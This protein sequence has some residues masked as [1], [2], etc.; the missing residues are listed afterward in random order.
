[1]TK[2]L[3]ISG[4]F[5]GILL[6]WLL[7]LV[8]VFSFAIRTSP[9]QTYLAK[10][11][12]K[13]LSKELHATL[14]IDNV[15]IIFIDKVEL[16]G[17]LLEDQ[18]GDTILY[19][20]SL[21]ASIDHFHLPGNIFAL[22]EVEID[23]G[24]IAIE[25]DKDGRFSYAFLIDY[26][27]RDKKKEKVPFK[28][29]V[30]E[31]NVTNTQ[32]TYDDH[33]KSPSEYGIDYFHLLAKEIDTKVEDFTIENGVYTGRIASLECQ[34]K[35]GFK[36]D[37]LS[38]DVRVD[39]SGV[40]LADVKI[41]SPGS[42]V[43]SKKFNMRSTGLADFKTFV[44]SVKFDG[45]LQDS[46]V[47]LK[48]IAYFAPVLE[49][50]IDTLTVRG[51]IG[52]KTTNLKLSDIH[53]QYGK[54]TSLHGTFVI[55]DY[56]KFEKGF[57]HEQIHYASINLRE[58]EQIR[59]PTKAG[60]THIVLDKR[61]KRLEHIQA[62]DIKMTGFLTQ[63]VIAAD[64]ITT[65]LGQV[66]ADNGI[67][68]TQYA[69]SNGYFFE[70]SITNEYDVKIE[71]F[72]L[73][74]MLAN[75]TLGIV[76]G[77]FLLSGEANS[78]SDVQFSSIRGK[79]D[80]FDYL[81]YPYTDI[82]ILEGSL[83]DERFEGTIEVQ[84][85]NLDM[86]YSGMV[87]FKT[88]LHLLFTI[89][90][91]NALLEKLNITEDDAQVSSIFTVDLKGKNPDN[92]R[93]SVRMNSFEMTRNQ[94]Y[95]QVPNAELKIV[96]GPTEDQFTIQS[97]ILQL[98]VRGKLYLRHI[99]S[100]FSNN[101]AGVF[102]ALIH[103]DSLIVDPK[104]IDHFTFKAEFFDTK[105][106]LAIFYPELNIASHTQINGH[107][108][109]AQQELKMDITSDRLR[110]EQMEFTNLT[111]H[112]QMSS[113]RLILNFHTEHYQLNDSINFSNVFFNTNGGN[114]LLESE[115][116]WGHPSQ[117]PSNISWRT[118]VQSAEKFQ[119]TLNPSYFHL[120]EKKWE[121]AHSSEITVDSDTL[122]I[123]DFELTRKNQFIKLNGDISSNDDH[124][125]HFSLKD[126]LIQEFS[127]L[128]STVPLEGTVNA[129]GF[130]SN[131]F[132]NFQFQGDA[133]IQQLIAKNNLV[134][135]VQLHSNW[136][137]ST[138]SMA[139]DGN[140][141]Y[142]GNQTFDFKG[143]YFPYQKKDNLDFNLVFDYMDIQFVN[144][145]MN[146]EVLADI[147]G[148]LNGT[149][150]V[151][152][153]IDRPILNGAVNLYAGSALVDIVGAHFGVEG[154]IKADQYGFYIDGIPVYDEDGNAGLMIGSIYHDNFNNF[155]FDLV[156]DLEIDA[157]NK[158][159]LRPW[160]PIPLKRFLLLNS[161]YEQGAIYHG[162]GYGTGMI[163]LFGYTDNLEVTVDIVTQKGTKIDIPMYGMG[164]I[165]EEN[166]IVF[167]D[168]DTTAEYIEPKIDFTGVD[169][170]LNFKITP[171][172]EVKIIF[173]KEL[174]DE[175]VARGNGDLSIGLNNIGDVRMNGV[176][177]VDEGVYNFAMG[178][179]KEKFYLDKG[180]SISW[181][182]DPYD[183]ILNLRAYYKV[184]ANIAAATNDQ[185]GSGSG[186]HQE[187]LC[188]LDLT[189]SLI[190]PTIDFD[191]EAPNANEVA[192]SVITR[193][194]SDEDELNRQFF[195]LL[196]WKRFQPL[197]GNLS[198]DGSAAID[199]ITNQI[200]AIL[201]KVSD[202]YK[203]NVNMD[204]DELTGDNTYEFGVSKGFLND[205]LILSGS[206]GV[207]NR[208]KTEEL[209][210][211]NAI[212][213]DIN[214][215]YLLNESGTFRVNIFNESND[216]TII[217]NQEQGSFKQGVGLYYKEDFNS[218]KDFK[219]VQYFF[220]I[221]RKK[222]NKRYPIK[223]KKKQV[224]IRREE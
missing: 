88:E 130:I 167:V 198:T 94:K 175:I 9:F 118:N 81:N 214:L 190:K 187:V 50:M 174:E 197:A 142:K 43:R 204:S 150:K 179:I 7:I 71:Q 31:I 61:I 86:T 34:E 114:N 126:I 171:E 209:E 68:F 154:K 110:Y 64:K 62:N 181:T 162:K 169:L 56:R 182:G 11:V 148:L 83:R 127:P 13:S 222:S 97:Q 57:F 85:D 4:R 137:K 219:A 178:P 30:K 119:F 117:Y 221:F 6:E 73:G 120:K 157:I 78:V 99:V 173:N 207:E 33:R 5:L 102:P 206:F 45:E 160:I 128:F 42:R 223:R 113:N 63:F 89:D 145:V 158:D 16:Q 36:L 91:Q 15:S 93:G 49:G 172:A 51:K 10:I 183:A 203:L 116:V 191:L 75:E 44:D 12:T 100:N 189:E 35:S 58:L 20:K 200:N 22:K 98:D 138:R 115:L 164:E 131:P 1:M 21:Y 161:E 80:R 19:A 156:F 46:R 218:V 135:D 37:A 212:I 14:N 55:P 74:K 146:P 163:E 193:I 54:Y 211:E 69:G 23:G 18:K 192:K 224:P 77:T 90:I 60:A 215:E 72:N 105:D 136:N 124:R 184:N 40:Y 201:A 48:E 220:D 144:A 196:L 8:I 195:S 216:K 87:D 129:W 188:Y 132:H 177:T 70:E 76:D 52:Q 32:F 153:E 125:L 84:D 109:G 152:G 28:F 82:E 111:V 101:L 147:K 104:K 202:E 106:F 168:K 165:E 122:R 96:R 2:I 103:S 121:I 24:K 194:K 17:V 59:L 199:L 29:Q 108:F 185:L 170:D 133:D 180:G 213:G 217:Q 208:S 26:F 149:L 186:A 67:M 79:V 166:F 123:R 25:R 65:S 151:T 159:P 27:K 107:Y 47:H 3:K 66:R 143:N 112:Q 141:I 155:N 39:H 205:R 95:F 139:M 53:L 41:D 176:F 134:G 38:T 92:F 210:D 140:L